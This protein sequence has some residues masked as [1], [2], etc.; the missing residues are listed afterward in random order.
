MSKLYGVSDSLGQIRRPLTYSAK[1]ETYFVHSPDPDTPI[2][3]T[4]DGMQLVYA[5]GKYKNV[6]H[7]F[8]VLCER[9]SCSEADVFHSSVSR[10]L[11]RRM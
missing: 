9:V 1:I 2:E 10:I 6:G 5:S 7:T 11:N 8:L 3:Q 4:V